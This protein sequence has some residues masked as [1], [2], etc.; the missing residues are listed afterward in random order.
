MP[1]NRK[2]NLERLLGAVRAYPLEHRRRITF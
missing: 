1:I 2:W